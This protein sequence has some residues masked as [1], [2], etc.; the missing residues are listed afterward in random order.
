MKKQFLLIIKNKNKIHAARKTDAG[1]DDKPGYF[2][3]WPNV[4]LLLL[5][6]VIIGAPHDGPDLD[7][8]G[9]GNGAIYIYHGLASGDMKEYKQV[10]QTYSKKSHQFN[11]L[12]CVLH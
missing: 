2:F 11:I 8:D 9:V 3:I 6:D 10:F 7:G 5:P 1:A 4:S 12:L